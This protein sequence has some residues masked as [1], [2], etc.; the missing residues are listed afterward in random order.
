MGG[1]QYVTDNPLD[2]ELIQQYLTDVKEDHVLLKLI[3][4]VI[5]HSSDENQNLSL[6]D[7]SLRDLVTELQKKPEFDLSLDVIN[8]VSRNEHLIRSLLDIVSEN[9]VPKKEIK[10]LEINLTNGLLAEEVDNHLA[11]SHIYPID[12]S[13]SIAV[14]NVDTLNDSYRKKSFKISEWD[15]KKSAF[16]SDVSMA[17]LLIVK[18]T[19]DLWDLKLDNF[20]QESY[21]VLVT[22]G[23][24]LSVF[25]YKFTEP[26]LALNGFNGQSGASNA[27]LEQ[28]IKDFI[29]SAQKVGFS[30]IGK[31]ADSI[32]SMAVLFRKVETTHPELPNKKYVIKI[33]DNRRQEW[34]DSI[35][36]ILADKKEDEKNSDAVWLIANDSD[37]NGVVGLVNCLRLEPGGESVRCLFDVDKQ[38]KGNFD[39]TLFYDILINDLAVNVLK[40]GQLGTYRHLTL[41]K[42]YDKVQSS[43]YFLNIGQNRDLSSLQWYESKN[44]IP[45]EDYYDINNR[46]TKQIRC[47]I[48]SSGLNF[49]DVMLAT[50][51]SSFVKH[52]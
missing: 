33:D 13:Y 20:V 19:S 17:N 2:E 44:L 47:N 38:F 5:K 39:D 31:K 34:F 50:G 29:S 48:Y 12:V 27:G 11:S 21:D 51:M 32:G 36:Q 4:E 37:T 3:N 23:F 46:K 7:E 45:R 22:K 16:P 42:D 9:Y 24:L 8:Q 25:K 35:K 15:H 41:P 10:V 1:Q 14:K 30:L 52:F 26:E 6:K 43:E 49:R 28:R 40:N 18:D